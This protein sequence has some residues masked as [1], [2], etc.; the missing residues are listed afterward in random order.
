[1]KVLGASGV[2]LLPLLPHRGLDRPKHTASENLQRK[3][4][5]RAQHQAWP[6]SHK[7]QS[8]CTLAMY[9]ARPP[10][11]L[12]VMHTELPKL[13]QD[14]ANFSSPDFFSYQCSRSGMRETLT[15]QNPGA[16]GEPQIQRKQNAMIQKEIKIHEYSSS[17]H[18]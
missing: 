11:P 15:L 3:Q 10:D 1:M 2:S 6:H 9:M 14:S 18:L 16:G 17:F 13:V 5:A 8:P 7:P 4:Q 12:P